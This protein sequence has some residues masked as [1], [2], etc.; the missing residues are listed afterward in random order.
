MAVL[1][2][3]WQ[4]VDDRTGVSKILGP[5]LRHP[6]PADARWWYVFG[7]ATLFAFLL[8]VMTGIALALAYIPS[9]ANAYD[10]LQF[11]THQAPF[12]NVLRGM[13][14]FGASAMVL[15]IG[16][17]MA[18]TFL[19]GAYKFPREV[20]WLT[21]V[22]LFGVT[23]LIAF[24]GQLLRWDQ[25][26][27]WSIAVAAEQAGRAPIIGRALARFLLAG[28]TWGGQT[29]SRFFAFHVF[30]IP[31]LIFVFVG[32][33]LWLVLHHGISE[34]PKAGRPVD[35]RTY[36]AWYRDLLHREGRPFWPDAA[37]RDIVFGVSMITAV[38]LAALIFGPPELGKPPDPTILQADPRP[39]WYL[40]WYFAVLALLPPGIENYVIILAPLLAGVVLI[41]VPLVANRG[42]RHPARRP[43]AVAILLGIALMIGTFWIFG[44]Q[45]PWSPDF[46]AGPLPA[47]I[48]GAATGPVSVGARL[49]YEKGCEYCH[50]VAG[51]GGRRGPDLT[52]VGDRLTQ[53]ELTWR[54]L[55]GGTNMPAFAG[56]LTPAQLD[57]LVA[58]LKS[59]TTR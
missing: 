15:L 6:V 30:F 46:S 22:V 37:W 2:R 45:S 33:H 56:N 58:F 12:G 11:I 47:R 32:V 27:V 9:T 35:P 13:H 20:N 21:G 26:A 51:H 57:A 8:Q 1:R 36:R 38:V 52:T 4:V 55:N 16:I 41:L 25:T 29:L 17:H 14:Y 31:A 54:I 42:E 43:W 59:R 7:S 18:R 53:A 10:T 34:P 39:D 19:M 24:T 23:I 40:L 3:L 28:D 48:V 44:A 50:A 5:V 49:F